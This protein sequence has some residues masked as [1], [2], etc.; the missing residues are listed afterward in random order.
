[1]ITLATLATLRI[2]L[3]EARISLKDAKDYEATARAVAETTAIEGGTNGKNAD[4]RA[5]NL[6]IA[7]MDDNYYQNAR[8]SL[9]DAEAKVDHLQAEIANYEDTIRADEA[10]IREK[11]ADALMGKRVDD[12]TADQAFDLTH[13]GW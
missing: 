10:R 4:E 3:A 5:R 6:T 12:L 7:L 1:M 13:G 11:L 2:A 8:I 9:R